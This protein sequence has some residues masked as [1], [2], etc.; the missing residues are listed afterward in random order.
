MKKIHIEINFDMIWES[1]SPGTLD[2]QIEQLLQD[3]YDLET[4]SIEINITQ[5]PRNFIGPNDPGDENEDP[6][7]VSMFTKDKGILDGN[8]LND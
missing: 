1:G 8:P 6:P 5:D 4:G 2:Y 3:Q 7:V